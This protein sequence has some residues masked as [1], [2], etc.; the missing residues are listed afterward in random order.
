[1]TLQVTPLIGKFDVSKL[2]KLPFPIDSLPSGWLLDLECSILYNAAKV[3]EGPVV[4]VGTWE[5]RSTCCLAY[6]LQDNPR[7]PVFDVFDFGDCGIEEFTLRHGSYKP[8]DDAEDKKLRAVVESHGG[9]A[10]KLKQNLADR[11]LGRMV[12][13]FH[14]GDFAHTA[15]N[16]IYEVAFCDVSH[17]RDEILRNVTHLKKFIDPDNYL[18]VF[19]DTAIEEECQLVAG[20]IEP[21]KVVCFGTGDGK[22][23]WM[24]SKF[25]IT[26]KGKYAA[27]PWLQ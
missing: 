8:R 21:D 15:T 12:T 23:T 13:M 17:G 9:I 2:D 18:I 16:R 22:T 14:F 27:L 6:G 3:A 4:E 5:G 25:T 24:H 1:M 26:A 7:R 11:K 10:G 20:I 19:D